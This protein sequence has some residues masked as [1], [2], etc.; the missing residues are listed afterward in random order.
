LRHLRQ[1]GAGPAFVPQGSELPLY[2][3][4]TD[5]TLNPKHGRSRQGQFGGGALFYNDYRQQRLPDEQLTWEE[6]SRSAKR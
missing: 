1:P 3:S 6:L 2:Q 4:L 5:F